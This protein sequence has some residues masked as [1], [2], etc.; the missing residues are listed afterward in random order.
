MSN[1]LRSLPLR[2][3]LLLCAATLLLGI[4]STTLALALDSGPT[5]PSKPLANAIHDALSAPAPSGLTAR[6]QLVNHLLEG[7]ELQT[8]S[9]GGSPNP[10]LSGGSG[11]LWI[12]ADGD[13]RLEL[14]SEA[15]ATQLLYDG[16][17]ITLYQAGSGRL[18]EYTPPQEGEGAAGSSSQGEANAGSSSQSSEARR[19]PSV[20]SIERELTRLMGRLE[21]SGATPTDVAGAPAYSTSLSPRRNGGLLGNVQLTWD[22][23]HGV[24]LRFAIYAKGNPAPAVE[25]RVTE[26]SFGPVPSSI[27]SLQLPS[28]LK[29]TKIDAGSHSAKGGGDLQSKPESLEEVQAALPFQLQAPES[30]AGM[31]RSEV[32]LIEAEGGRAASIGYGEGLGGIGVIERAIETGE[33]GEAGSMGMKLPSISIDGSKGSELA[34]ELGTLISFRREGVEYLLAGSVTASTLEAAAQGL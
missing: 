25:L 14:Q 27:F 21:I 31:Q 4:G 6:V 28:G 2:R 16:S 12:A 30:L 9:E 23:Q 34:T 10:L 22:S 7:A 26:V 18:Y 5:P 11:R 1:H 24:P 3:L 33:S 13:I 20:A 8:Q 15:G 19:V 32:R 29:V 17:K